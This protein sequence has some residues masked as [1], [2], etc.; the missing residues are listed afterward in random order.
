MDSYRTIELT[1]EEL[2]YFYRV[3]KKFYRMEDIKSKLEEMLED[4]EGEHEK[5]KINSILADTERIESIAERFD[6]ALDNND[7]YWE[8]YWLTAKY[9]IEDELKEG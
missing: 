6:H 5:E 3:C 2:D 1:D 4:S 9:V 7:S 8:S